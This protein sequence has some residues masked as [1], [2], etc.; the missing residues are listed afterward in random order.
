MGKD[1]S[2]AEELYQ[3]LISSLQLRFPKFRLIH[4]GQSRSQR[5]VDRLLRI[6]TFGQMTTYLTDYH[7][8]F[9]SKVYVLDRWDQMPAAKRYETLCHEAA[10]IE[11]FERYTFLGMVLFYVLLPFPLGLAYFRA[12]M[13]KSAYAESMRARAKLMGVA[14]LADNRYRESI[15]RQFTGPEYGWMWP[16]PRRIN[17]WYDSIQKQI[18]SEI[19]RDS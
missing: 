17:E 14:A 13:E 11:Q 5:I 3:D 8:T 2:V 16:F 12:Q 9:G 10:H 15:V 6:F 18:E 1:E 4:K 19:E 7:T